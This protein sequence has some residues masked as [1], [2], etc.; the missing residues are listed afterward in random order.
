MQKK[1]IPL[2]TVVQIYNCTVKLVR[3]RFKVKYRPSKS[4]DS[5]YIELITPDEMR[6]NL[7][8]SDHA[9]KDKRTRSFYLSKNFRKKDLEDFIEDG[10][11]RAQMKLVKNLFT[12]IA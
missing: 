3:S 8:F 2:T 10:I 9:P 5:F 1:P 7:R 12:K 6:Y 4:T 11:H